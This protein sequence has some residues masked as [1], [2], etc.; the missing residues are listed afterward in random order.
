MKVLSFDIGIN[1]LSFIKIEYINN[2][3]NIDKWKTISLFLPEN[4]LL[5]THTT[6]KNKLCNKKAK[7]YITEENTIYSFCGIHS[8]KKDQDKLCKINKKKN[9]KKT[10]KEICIKLIETFDELQLCD[11]DYVL[12]EQQ[13]QRNAQMKNI[14]LLLF[15]YFILRGMFDKVDNKIKDVLFISSKNKLKFYDGP[16]III[17]SKNNY[18][19]RKKL[20]IEYCKYHLKENE[21]KN[22]LKYFL[23][24]KKKDDA[25]DCFLQAIWFF[26]K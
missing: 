4:I 18:T 21:N 22:D 7:F 11:V 25:A 24:L 5:C 13:P 14:S 2:K 9:K 23:S 12:L 15:N 20:A 16:E 1:N 8:K 6:Q 19:K 26:N 10:L 3:Y 17:K